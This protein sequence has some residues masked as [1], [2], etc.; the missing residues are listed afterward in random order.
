MWIV[1]AY[2]NALGLEQAL[3]LPPEARDLEPVDALCNL[4]EAQHDAQAVL[5]GT[6]ESEASS[7]CIRL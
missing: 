6:G 3:A 7:D 2:Q 5:G 1:G 4:T